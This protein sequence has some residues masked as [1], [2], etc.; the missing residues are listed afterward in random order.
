MTT[1][2]D[3]AEQLGQLLADAHARKGSQ[4]TV[5]TELDAPDNAAAY[6]AQRAFLQRHRLDI[7]GWKI[8]AK[9][10][11][12]PIQGAPLPRQGI[13]ASGATLA[14]SGFPL[15]GIELEIMFRFGRDFLPDAAPVADA[16][17]LASIAGIAASIEIVSSRL[18]GWPD[19]PKPNQLADLQNHGALIIGEFVDYRGEVDVRSPQARLVLDGQV[20]FDGAGSNPAGDPRRLLPWLVRHCREQAIALPAG[21]VVTAGSYT[22]MVFPQALGMVTG[23]IAG[24]PAVGF[25]IT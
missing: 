13:H 17:V 4:V 11:D 7:G 19:V 2:P 6:R 21:T 3:L 14:R 12:G 10:E 16:E 24:L 18:A 8:G 5:P 23:T 20:I 25:E 22:G 1:H 15:F 9:S